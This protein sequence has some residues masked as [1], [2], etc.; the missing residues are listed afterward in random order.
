[1]TVLS[2]LP[3]K[4]G[5][6][7]GQ[8]LSIW[9]ENIISMR[10]SGI[11][12]RLKIKLPKGEFDIACGKRYWKKRVKGLVETHTELPIP[13]YDDTV[14]NERRLEQV[15][16][17]QELGLIASAQAMS[18]GVSLPPEME[19][20]VP[21]PEMLTE[22]RLALRVGAGFLFI[23]TGLMALLAVLIV[24]AG[25]SVSPSNLIAAVV[26]VIIGIN[27]WRGRG[28]QWQGWAIARAA[29]GLLVFGLTSLLQGAF[30]QFL[31]QVAFCGSLILVLTGESKRNR[32]WASI[33]L[34]VGHLGTLLLTL[35]IGFLNA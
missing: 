17:F 21:S 14:T 30:L 26:D 9:R 1:M 31:G 28:N 34:Y 13:Q 10:W 24:L 3:L 18:E 7:S 8:V 25:G 35:V 11:W 23:N 5:K 20:A 16:V 27:L 15:K 19:S 4:R 2:I 6:P 29:L 22:K 32:T 12:D 33:A